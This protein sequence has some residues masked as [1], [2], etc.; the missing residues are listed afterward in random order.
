MS[1][2]VIERKVSLDMGAVW[3]LCK[4]SFSRR[5]PRP[6]FFCQIITNRRY[7]RQQE[8]LRKKGCGCGEAVHVGDEYVGICGGIY[9]EDAKVYCAAC[10]AIRERKGRS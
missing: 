2:H 6:A 7:T 10:A 4:P 8:R 9:P 1:R 5:T 3:D